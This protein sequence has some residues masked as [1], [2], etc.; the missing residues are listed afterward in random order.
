MESSRVL[1]DSCAAKSVC[2]QSWGRDCP[3]CPC[4]EQ[5]FVSATGHALIA[6]QIRTVTMRT[7]RG[8]LLT[9]KFLVVDDDMLPKNTA[10]LSVSGV[11][12]K[13]YTAQFYEDFGVFKQ[14]KSGDEIRFERQWGIYV[15]EVT[16]AFASA[17]FVENHLLAPLTTSLDVVDQ[18]PL[19]LD[20]ALPFAVEG[21]TTTDP[22]MAP[23]PYKPTKDEIFKHR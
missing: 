6:K 19:G 23:I 21:E 11:A 1:V 8:V 22:K 16:I 3:T 9:S 15:L 13:G 2:A 20:D 18:D 4:D 14:D 10:I 5:R 12:E 7:K 17:E